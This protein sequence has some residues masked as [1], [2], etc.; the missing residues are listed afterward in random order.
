MLVY[1]IPKNSNTLFT[2][3]LSFGKLFVKNIY[4]FSESIPPKK[5]TT[6]II[7]ILMSD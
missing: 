5:Y 7:N 2:V 6:I 3:L 1:I 4:A